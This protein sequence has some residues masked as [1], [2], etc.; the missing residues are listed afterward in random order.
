MMLK[1][2]K[3]IGGALLFLRHIDETGRECAFYDTTLVFPTDVFD[4]EAGVR[5]VDMSDPADPV[6]TA[7][8]VTPAMLTP[9]ESLVLS[10]E[11]GRLVAVAGNPIANVGHVDVDPLTL[12]R[13]FVV[14]SPIFLRHRS[15]IEA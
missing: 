12:E 6:V 10:E 8:L 1:K 15:T 14:R 11:T 5:A 4:A 13:A 2:I 7:T 9:H 3:V